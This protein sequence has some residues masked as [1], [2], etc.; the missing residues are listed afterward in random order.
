[1]RVA[2]TVAEEMDCYVHFQKEVRL[3]PDLQEL[4]R[5]WHIYSACDGVFTFTSKKTGTVV[6]RVGLEI[7]SEAPDGYKDL[8]APK[9][10]H[11]RQGHMYMAVLDLPLMWFFYMNKGNQ[12]NTNSKAPF[13]V[14]WQPDV[15]R[16]IEDRFRTVH[17]FASTKTLPERSE[18]IW[19]EFCPWRYTC[20]P[21]NFARPYQPNSGRMETIRP[22]GT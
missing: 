10:E 1:M 18:G 9:P 11:V 5:Y 17:E 19:C 3:S 22:R 12:N 14:I 2:S 6:L 13:L 21:S 15:W 20:Q 7:K 4:A 16:E 8:K